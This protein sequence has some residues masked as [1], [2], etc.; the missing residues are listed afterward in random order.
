MFTS[1]MSTEGA[2]CPDMRKDLVDYL[3]NLWTRMRIFRFLKFK[4]EQMPTLGMETGQKKVLK[5][6]NRVASGTGALTPRFRR[7][8]MAR[9]SPPNVSTDTK[10]KE[11]GN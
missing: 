5:T 7:P 3:H 8:E 9:R 11:L 1:L 4:M 6:Q 2:K 10:A